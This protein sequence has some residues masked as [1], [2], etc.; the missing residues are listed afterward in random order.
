MRIPLNPSDIRSEFGVSETDFLVVVP[1]RLI[2]GKGH[3]CLL[4]AVQ[5]LRDQRGW[6]PMVLCCGDGHTRGTE[7]LTRAA[8]QA[9]LDGQ[10]KFVGLLPHGRLFPLLRA[11]DCVTIPS[12][13]EGFGIA[14]AEAM[15]L[16]VP[17][18]L[19]QTD[20]FEELVGDSGSALMTQPNDSAGLADALWLLYQDPALRRRL[21]ELGRLHVR[22]NFDISSCAGG[23]ISIFD[24]LRQR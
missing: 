1:A 23:W 14:A 15:A 17:I 13:G 4:D 21:G 2:P 10:V 12:L 7:E 3:A 24:R 22:D 6:R 18:A 8:T 16:G 5:L 20:G 19:T 9:K 11:A